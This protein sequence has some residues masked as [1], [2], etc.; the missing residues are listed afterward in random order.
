[1]NA[2]VIKTIRDKKAR[3]TETETLTF[4]EDK[5]GKEYPLICL[6][7]EVEYQTHEGIGGAFTEAA[8]TTL[9]KMSAEKREEIL[10]AYFD[11]DAGI[12]YNFCR[13]HIN[14]CD[15]ALGN[16][17]YV[18]EGDETL[19]TF[20]ISHDKQS[21]IPMIKDAKK[22]GD[23]RLFA[24][25]WSPPAYMKDSKRMNLGG[26]LLK[27]Y[28]PLWAE[29]FAKYIQAYKDEGIDIWGVSVQNEAKATQLWDS[30]V[31]TAEEERD[32]I[33]DHLGEKMQ[34]LGVDILFWDHNKERVYDR[35]KVMYDD[36]EA[37]KYVAGIAFHWYSGDHFEQLAITKEQ[38]PDKKLYFSEGCQEHS[39]EIA[40]EW[41]AGERY[42]HDMIGNF[43]N[44]CCAFTDWNMLLN[45]KGG[46]NHVHNYCDA[47]IMADT[48]KDEVIYK[49]SYYYIGHMSKYIKAGAK[50]I[51]HSKYT[52]KLDVCSY[53][54]P[55]GEIV[56]VVMNREETK[57]ELSLMLHGSYA[58]AV[59]EPHSIATFLIR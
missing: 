35:A 33:K 22:Y 7:P 14:S 11:G 49:P 17:T 9:D 40:S 48:K 4:K 28:Y 34:K 6:F 15:F 24:S 19:E 46:P 5:K 58:K 30:C 8:S 2:K 25:P 51:G 44:H 31:Y 1:M 36:K 26:K 38:Y 21:L 10:K 59:L 42:A 20:D 39:R 56:V 57:A 43:N 45:E 13:T 54:N 12:G 32:F 27:E 53:K 16:Y 41:H 18:E 37:S 52:D 23:F 3:L 55:D 50:R 29:Y 47:P